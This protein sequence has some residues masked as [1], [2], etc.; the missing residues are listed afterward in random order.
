[1]GNVIEYLKWR[2]DLNFRERPFCEVDNLVLSLLIYA[3]LSGIVP[4]HGTV[5][6]GQV[7]ELYCGRTDSPNVY[8]QNECKNLFR[9]MADTRRY[10][11]V[12]LSDYWDTSN[13]E[14]QFAA[15]QAHLDDGTKYIA[16][17]GTDDSIAGWREDFAIS[18]QVTPAQKQAVRYL[19]ECMTERAVSTGSEDTPKAG[20]LR[21]MRP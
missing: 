20:T 8:L 1:M 10:Q 7:A 21:S 16:F 18:F 3:D 19:E 14:T 17:R 15:V 13:E 6:L 11:G 5:S 4:E 2:G 9:A 12:I